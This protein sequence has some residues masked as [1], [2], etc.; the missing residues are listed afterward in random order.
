M[1]AAA[2]GLKNSFP[3]FE[4]GSALL[5]KKILLFNHLSS[6]PLKKNT[7]KTW[8]KG[9]DLLTKFGTDFFFY[10]FSFIKIMSLIVV[11]VSR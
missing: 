9:V 4:N 2:L 7:Q 1:T 10:I 5:E 3:V 8:R 6:V 11:K